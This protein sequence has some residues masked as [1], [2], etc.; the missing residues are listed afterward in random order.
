MFYP[1]LGKGYHASRYGVYEPSW[2][3]FANRGYLL[4]Q[5]IAILVS[6][7]VLTLGLLVA[8]AWI[9][10]LLRFRQRNLLLP[11]IF[12][13]AAGMLTIFVG[14]GGCGAVALRFPILVCGNSCAAAGDLDRSTLRLLSRP[15][16]A[17]TATALVCLAVGIWVGGESAFQIA[18]RIQSVG[19]ALKMAR[20][21]TPMNA[22]LRSPALEARYA[23][24]QQH[25][26]AGETLICHLEKPYLLNFNRNPVL[27]RRLGRWPKSSA[28][29][30]VLQRPRSLGRLPDWPKACATWP[31]LTQTRPDSATRLMQIGSAPTRT[32]GS[33][34]NRSAPSTFRITSTNF[35][36]RANRCT[37]TATSA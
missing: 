11:V 10:G 23:D 12:S 21:G 8:A 2:S 22:D 4:R 16:A 17:T 28:G 13:V 25:V 26:P 27:H 35:A 3:A 18:Q 30:A 32:P 34:P 15:R 24:M 7:E 1:F 36:N 9:A 33:D 20:A 14:G 31:T 5:I 6:R 37:T 29:N 19:T